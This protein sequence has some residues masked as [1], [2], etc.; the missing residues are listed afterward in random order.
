M[1]FLL[2]LERDFL[3]RKCCSVLYEYENVGCEVGTNISSELSHKHP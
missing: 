3:W 1:D 2:N